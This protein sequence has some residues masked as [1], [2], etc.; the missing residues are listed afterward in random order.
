MGKHIFSC[1][2]ADPVCHT[3]PTLHLQPTEIEES[4]VH[5]LDIST[6]KEGESAFHE[7]PVHI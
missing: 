5:N 6:A 7:E 4:T 3:Q 2:L 1:A